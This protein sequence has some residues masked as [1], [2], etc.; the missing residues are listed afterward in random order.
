MIA[1]FLNSSDESGDESDS[2][3]TQ[4]SSQVTKNRRKNDGYGKRKRRKRVFSNL[5]IQKGKGSYRCT[6]FLKVFIF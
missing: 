6:N 4:L 3:N 1:L 2:S 5:Q